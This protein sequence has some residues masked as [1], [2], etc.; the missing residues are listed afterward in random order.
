VTTR[1]MNKQASALAKARERRR[2]LD[3]A[4]D[5]QDRR[6]ERATATALLA[7]DARKAAELSLRDP[8]EGL[9][10]ALRRLVSQDVSIERAA[11]LL[12]ELDWAHP[13]VPMLADA[14]DVGEPLSDLAACRDAIASLLRREL[15]AGAIAPVPTGDSEAAEILMLGSVVHLLV[16]AHQ[17]VVGR[18]RDGPSVVSRPGRSGRR[19]R[20]TRCRRTGDG[21]AEWSPRS[22]GVGRGVPCAPRFHPCARQ[23]PDQPR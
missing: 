21:P 7:L 12:E 11:A 2:E 13:A 8:T 10:G 20:R 4:R 14:V 3:K 22:P 15:Q 1:N 17:R 5:D 9:A 23:S 19:G 16:T 18:L 6:V